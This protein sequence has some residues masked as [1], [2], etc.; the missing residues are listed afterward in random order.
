MTSYT[1]SGPD[2]SFWQDDNSTAQQIDFAKMRNA[3]P[4]P[5]FVGIKVSESTYIDQDFIYNWNNAK[6]H[7]IPR[8]G[9]AFLSWDKSGKEQA[10]TYYGAIKADP[11]EVMAVCDY[12]KRKGIPSRSQALD[13]LYN[14]MEE[15]KMLLD[16]QDKVRPK[17]SIYTGISF[18][19]E[20]G[21][22]S[23]YWAQYLLWLAYYS[24]I[25]PATPVPW[26]KWTLWQCGTPP[27]GL[28]YG[29][30]SKEIDMNYY[31]GTL[32]QFYAEFNLDP[33]YYG[34]VLEGDIPI[35]EEPVVV[36]PAGI[37][38][39]ITITGTPYVNIRTSPKISNNIVGRAYPGQV[40]QIVNLQGSTM[41]AETA[42]GK[43]IAIT[44]NG[45]Q[46]AVL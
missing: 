31:K 1:V 8:L 30:E 11:P 26:D 24:V 33:E 21:S 5:R 14:F 6:I 44:Y 35:P 22:S 45:N 36:N 46:L 29:A 4:T 23:T 19:K 9:Y 32:E 16:L 7:R 10:R 20:F 17:E 38:E 3:I 12:E 39:L 37:D 43:F 2:V 25:A 27:V 40:L 34:A 41:W 18:W 15:L 28:E 13:I 42:D